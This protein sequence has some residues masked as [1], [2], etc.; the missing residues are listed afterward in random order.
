VKS[1]NQFINERVGFGNLNSSLPENFLFAIDARNCTDEEIDAVFEEFEK[2]V[3]LNDSIKKQLKGKYRPW[4][5]RVQI[6]NRSELQIYIHDITTPNWGA[7]YKWMEDI[8]TIK[9]FLTV[10]LE[11]VKEYIESGIGPEMKKYNI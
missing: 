5:W 2:Y 9:D 4:A 7:G 10:G 8:I 1:Y 6:D 11:N 3:N